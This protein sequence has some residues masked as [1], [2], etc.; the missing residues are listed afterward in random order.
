MAV[1]RKFKTAALSAI[2][3]FATA[4]QKLGAIGQTT[5]RKFDIAVLATP[6]YGTQGR[7][8]VGRHLDESALRK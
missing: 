5:M 7:E 6:T 3:S 8:S 1:Q 4:L 2:H